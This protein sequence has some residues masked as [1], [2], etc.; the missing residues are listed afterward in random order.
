V[1][2]ALAVLVAAAALAA[3]DPRLYQASMPPPGSIGRLH[4]DHRWAELTEGSAL[5]FHCEDGGPCLRAR[6]TSDDPEIADVR[7]AALARLEMKVWAGF[8]QSSTFVIIGK[9]PGTTRIRVRSADG[10]TSLKVTVLP[11]P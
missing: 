6:A 10:D 5:A 4:T 2:R 11:A 8:S 1:T 7:P 3:C 9:N